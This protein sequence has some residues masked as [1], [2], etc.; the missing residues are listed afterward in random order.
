M[1]SEQNGNSF[2]YSDATFGIEAGD[3]DEQDE[4]N[5]IVRTANL[6]N[7]DVYKIGATLNVE[8]DER[9]TSGAR[10]RRQMAANRQ[11]HIFQQNP[12]HPGATSG[13]TNRRPSE[14]CRTSPTSRRAGLKSLDVFSLRSTSTVILCR[15][16]ISFYWRRAMSRD[17]RNCRHFRP[18]FASKLLGCSVR[19]R[20][21]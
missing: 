18:P 15:A 19:S 9:R 4:R 14:H 11:T 12:G 16:D 6:V 17:F 7:E 1:R 8:R 13:A 20:V 2:S 3:T 10:R 21:S 5:R